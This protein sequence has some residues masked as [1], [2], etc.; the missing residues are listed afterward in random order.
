MERKHIR[1]LREC[2]WFR[3]SCHFEPT[4]IFSHKH[5]HW[6]QGPVVS[7]LPDFCVWERQRDRVHACTK[8]HKNRVSRC[9]DEKIIVSVFGGL[10]RKEKVSTFLKL[11]RTSPHFFST[12]FSKRAH[13]S[14]RREGVLEGSG[15]SL[16]H[17]LDRRKQ[18]RSDTKVHALTLA[19]P[20]HMIIS[21]N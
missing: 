12:C 7:N 11:L 15:S 10:R 21:S 16:V 18:S 1:N 2:G 9:E 20:Q 5:I 13:Q 14:Y 17:V 4:R 19:R 8:A 6:F 3:K